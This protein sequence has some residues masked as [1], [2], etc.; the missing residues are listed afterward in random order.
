MVL[1]DFRTGCESQPSQALGAPPRRG[2]S[3]K[4]PNDL[5]IIPKVVTVLYLPNGKA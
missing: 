1:I 2:T 4:S 3:L 5:Q